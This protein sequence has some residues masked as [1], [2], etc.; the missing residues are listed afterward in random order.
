MALLRMFP[1]IFLFLY[2]ILAGQ[3]LAAAASAGHPPYFRITVVDQETGRGVPAVKLQMLNRGQYW[4]DNN[5]VIAFNEPDL[6]NQPVWFTVETH[7]YVS[8]ANGF[9]GFKGIVLDI[10]PGG[11]AVVSIRRIN[12]A[13]RLYRMTGSGMY[14]ES[15]LLGYKVPPIPEPGK[16]PVMGQDGGD[17]VLFKGRYH[18][19]WGDT[20]ITRFPL[21]IFQSVSAVSDLP[22]NGGLDPDQGVVLRYLRK[23]N[24]EIRPII[25]LTLESGQPYWYTRMRVVKDQE[26]HEHLLTDYARVNSK[27]EATE[28]GLLEYSEQT[29]FFE[30]VTRYP[31]HPIFIAEGGG[32]T[33]PRHTVNGKDYFHHSGPYPVIRYPADYESQRDISTREAFTCLKEGLRY[34]GSALQLDRAQ[35]GHL[36]WGWRKNTSPVTHKQMDELVKAGFMQNEERW[37]SLYDIDSGK[38]IVPHEGSVYWNPFRKRWINILVQSF[39]ETL[40]GEVW[41]LEADTPQGPWVY[42]KKIITHNWPGQ[43]CS[44]YIGAQLPEFDR[45]GGRTIY[46]KGSFSSAFGDDKKDAP[47]HD[48]NIMVY[49]LELDDPRL[50]LPV[51]VYHDAEK[52]G[53]YGTKQDFDRADLDLVWFAPDR[54][55][56]GTLPIYQI[57]DQNGIRL[58]P[59][60]G[61]NAR[62][63]FF[64]LPTDYKFAAPVEKNADQ[65]EKGAEKEQRAGGAST[66]TPAPAAEKD[67]IFD[68]V[69]IPSVQPVALYEF[70]NANGKHRY[71]T[72]AS[73]QIPGFTRSAAPLCFVWPSP[74][75]FNPYGNTDMSLW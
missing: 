36:R 16:V 12:V 1:V 45:N 73:L 10:K 8:D 54:P 71:S 3:C 14:R 40:I 19:L 27:W 13:Q 74:I 69:P 61:K 50:F 37:Y 23:E 68:F 35:N 39:G 56:P 4:T 60:A 46:L 44:F 33:V 47:R 32:T 59:K 63:V 48:Y 22:E 31:D 18:W 66:A 58:T 72:D 29:G 20:G 15:L 38:S 65:K 43:T 17:M 28:R 26:G 2:L 55:A 7:G 6:M 34:D 11:S 53:R 62:K 51:P 5:G 75:L 21:G 64:A 25:N 49:K 52:T 67:K 9:L 57:A 70:R 42:A 24:G 41:Y 30:L